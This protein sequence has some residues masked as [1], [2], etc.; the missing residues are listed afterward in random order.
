MKAIS[1]L[2]LAPKSERV[3]ITLADGSTGEVEISGLT[4]RDI[5]DLM[6]RFPELREMMVRPPA[7][8]NLPPLA[9]DASEAEKAER[10]GQIA[11]VMADP[12]MRALLR[13]MPAM[14]VAGMGYGE[15][16]RERAERGAL[17]LPQETQAMLYGRIMALTA[18]TAANPQLAGAA[19]GGS[20]DG[21]SG[22][23]RAQK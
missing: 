18:E 19:A 22:K 10:L 13:I 1:L 16:D 7:A 9:P 14:I 4:A 17:S 2:D 21:Q 15:A 20:G 5:V 6:G 12:S 3:T 8:V 11:E 23:A